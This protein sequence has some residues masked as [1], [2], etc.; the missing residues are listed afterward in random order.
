MLVLLF[1]AATLI[2]LN[3][4]NFLSEP[5][6]QPILEGRGDLQI[7]NISGAGNVFT[8]AAKTQVVDLKS[9]GFSGE[10]LLSADEQTAFEFFFQGTRIVALPG[11]QIQY[12]PQTRELVIDRGE[13]YWE[14][15]LPNRR[16]EIALIRAANILS[17]SLAGR[18]RV[19]GKTVEV[20]NYAGQLE[21]RYGGAFHRVNPL[22]LAVLGEKEKPQ[23]QDIL[24]APQM[25]APENETHTL[26]QPSDTLYRFHWKTVP[27]AS[28]YLF[29]IYTSPLRESI[30][31]TQQVSGTS[32]SLDI[33]PYKQGRLYW[34]VCAY[35]PERDIES[36]PSQV[37]L[38]R[39]LGALLSQDLR[40]E[41]PKLEV[42]SLSVS[43]NMVLIKGNAD[44]NVELFIDGMSVR[45]DGDG[46][47]IHTLSYKTIGVKEIVF[48]AVAP[49]GL[50]TVVR[51]Q[52]T[53]FEE[54]SE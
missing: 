27:G 44:P 15:Q 47:F 48:R 18:L 45:V 10:A 24:P 25:I 8:D 12:T 26:R 21:C 51:R 19:R 39:L 36:Q 43:G 7:T 28:M 29:R 33:L 13:F 38:L 6:S 16:V 52:V 1:F 23:V 30:L 40:V 37:G 2:L 42:T 46:K 35:D 32:V 4:F 54:I 17:L 11:S 22:Q 53:I 41:P 31:A 34:D 3:Q 50:A 20:W 14:N 9:P 5:A 49:S